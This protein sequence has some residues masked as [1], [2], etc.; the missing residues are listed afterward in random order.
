[1][2]KSTNKQLGNI[3]QTKKSTCK[4]HDN[5]WIT[6]LLCLAPILLFILLTRFFPQFPYLSII[7]LLICPISMWF[8]MRS[9]HKEK[10]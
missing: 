6:M 4:T 8:M 3:T 7:A 10:S 9:M 5:S 1:M 2:K